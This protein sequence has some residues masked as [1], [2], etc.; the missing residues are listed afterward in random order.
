VKREPLL[1]R[2]VIVALA[3]ALLAALVVF[4]VDLSGKETKAILTLVGAL[5]PVL[6]AL[7]SRPKVTPDV[8]VVARRSRFGPRPVVA[9]PSSPLPDGTLVRVV[10]VGSPPD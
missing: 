2:G 9:G 3:T 4:G 6:V 10:P 1:T 7:L 5:A 8:D